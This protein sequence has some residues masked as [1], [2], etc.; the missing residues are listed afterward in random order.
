MYDRQ[1]AE[2][3]LAD[4]AD[5]RERGLCTM[6]D[7]PNPNEGRTLD[8]CREHGGVARPVGMGPQRPHVTPQHR[9]GLHSG[10]YS[11]EG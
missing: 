1:A 10:W 9:Q 3:R 8:R 5:R 2:D 6:P 4:M 7:C 11:R